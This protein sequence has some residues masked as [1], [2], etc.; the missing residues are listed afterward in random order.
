MVVNIIT[1]YS[2]ITQP[3][4]ICSGEQYRIPNGQN[5]LEIHFV[6][7]IRWTESVNWVWFRRFYNT[8]LNKSG[9]FKLPMKIWR[10]KEQN[11]LECHNI[12]FYSGTKGLTFLI[13]LKEV[14]EKAGG[15]CW[16][17]VACAM[18]LKK[19]GEKGGGA[20]CA[21]LSEWR[22]WLWRA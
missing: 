17:S 4:D 11:I 5:T 15:G 2:G 10:K 8:K 20:I 12:L 22:G 3:R 16:G 19:A 7:S 9:L 18:W 14:S 1:S 13:P 6:F 21:A